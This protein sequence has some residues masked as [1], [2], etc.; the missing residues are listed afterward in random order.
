MPFIHKYPFQDLADLNLDAWIKLIEETR[1]DIA[2]VKQKID[3]I[4]VL[5]PEEIDQRISNAIYANNIQIRR[6]LAQLEE[7]LTDAYKLAD[8]ALEARLLN[9][10]NDTAEQLDLKASAYASVALDNAKVYADALAYNA[11]YMISPVTGEVT[12]VQNVIYE[13]INTF[14]G[15][16]ILTASEYDAIELTAEDYDA[17][18]L[19]AYNYDMYGK[20]YLIGG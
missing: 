2:A 8:A 18:E 16:N 19:T 5:T 14:H 10:I 12:T 15:D 9:T 3:E 17:Y 1:A 11:A 6:E 13:I 4:E 20:T 7:D